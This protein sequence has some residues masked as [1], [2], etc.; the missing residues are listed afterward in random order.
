M[1]VL[2]LFRDGEEDFLRQGAD[3]GEHTCVRTFHTNA[4]H[5]FR[6]PII[7]GLGMKRTSPNGKK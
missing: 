2:P 1:Q 7:T 3:T 4:D 6:I 5:P